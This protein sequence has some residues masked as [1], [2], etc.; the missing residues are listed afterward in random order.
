[1]TQAQIQQMQK[2]STQ[3]AMVLYVPYTFGNNGERT[4]VTERQIFWHMRNAKIGHIDHIDCKEW[5]DKKGTNV[6]SWFVHFKTWTGSDVLTET[7]SNGGHFEVPYDKHGHYWKVMK[8]TPRPKEDTL[9]EDTRKETNIRIVPK[10]ARN[11]DE[12]TPPPQEQVTDLIANLV[13]C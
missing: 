9:K 5:T 2:Q 13:G 12:L 4:G 7:L 3:T 1:M 6:R 10:V 11:P 8:Y